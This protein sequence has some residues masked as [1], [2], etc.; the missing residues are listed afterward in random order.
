MNAATIQKQALAAAE[1][2]RTLIDDDAQHLMK[3]LERFHG[4]EWSVA[5]DHE[6]G[7]VLIA[8]NDP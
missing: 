5:I 4:G 6:S 8:R 1:D 2:W 3:A 7:F